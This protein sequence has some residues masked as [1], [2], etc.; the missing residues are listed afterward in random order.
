MTDLAGSEELLEL[1]NW[2]S[3]GDGRKEIVATYFCRYILQHGSV[4]VHGVGY[5]IALNGTL[6]YWSSIWYEKITDH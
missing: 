2:R 6:P 3:V 4:L 1:F 5:A